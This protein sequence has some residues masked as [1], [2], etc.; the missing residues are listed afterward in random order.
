MHA[1]LAHHRAVYHSLQ[2]CGDHVTVEI[3]GE[4]TNVG[5]LIENIECN[6][7]DVAAAFS[8]VC[9]YDTANSIRNNCEAAV[10]FLLPIEYVKTG[11]H[12]RTTANISSV[13]GGGQGGGPG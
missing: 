12:K 3:P 2:R 11:G 1:F 13:E 8:S 7:T 9:L 4:Q 10:A 6:D 5:Y